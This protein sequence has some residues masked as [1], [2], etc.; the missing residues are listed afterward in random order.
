MLEKALVDE[1]QY[2]TGKASLHRELKALLQRHQDMLGPNDQVKKRKRKKTYDR[3]GGS[4]ADV[5]FSHCLLIAEKVLYAVLNVYM[6][7]VQ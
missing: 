6:S 7:W 1:H 3:G 4:N 5:E 2:R